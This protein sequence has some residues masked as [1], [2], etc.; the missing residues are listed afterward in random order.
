VTRYHLAQINLAKAV[1]ALDSPLMAGFVSRLN[2]INAL[3]EQA[4]GFIWRLQSEAG[5]AT[6]IRVFDDPKIYI[7][8][9]VWETP[10]DLKNF[11]YR[12]AHVELIRDREA[13]FSRLP[14]QHQAAWWVPAGYRPSADEGRDRLLHLREQGP[15][16]IAFTLAR[17][18]A[19]P[20]GASCQQK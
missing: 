1:A 2:E 9:S 11:V 6:S 19:Q 8:M 10:E 20:I 7:N 15:S 12:S 14:V 18:F 16:A 3:A 4:K 13:W 17:P 5:D